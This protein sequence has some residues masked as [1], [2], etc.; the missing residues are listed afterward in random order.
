MRVLRDPLL[1]W[2]KSTKRKSLTEGRTAIGVLDKP[3]A[4]PMSIKQA[5]NVEIN[6][7]G[8]PCSHNSPEKHSAP[9][10]HPDAG[11]NEWWRGRELNP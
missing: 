5:P 10:V 1:D 7:L 9:E 3:V 6:V 8:S 4:T 11:L 2:A